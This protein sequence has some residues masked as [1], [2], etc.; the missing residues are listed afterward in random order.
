MKKRT[1]KTIQRKLQFLATVSV[2]LALVLTCTAF[3]TYGVLNLRQTKHQQVKTQ[4]ALLAQ[5]SAAAVEFVDAVQADRLL[6][7]LRAEPSVS[8]AGL[9]T[10]NSELIGGYPSK[11]DATEAFESNRLLLQGKHI[12]TQAVFADGETVGT[13]QMAVD[14]STVR[15]AIWN[16]AFIALVVGIGAWTVAIIVAGRLQR[17]IVEPIR[18]LGEVARK[19][20]LEGD[21]GHRVEILSDGEIGELI[22]AFNDLLAQTESSKRGL[23]D[24]KDM[25]ERRVAER[26]IE[27]EKACESAQAASRAK[28]DFLAN[29]SHEIRTPLNAIM[30]YADL[31]RRGWEDSPEE[32]N[33][34]LHT[35]HS[36]GRH[37][38]TVINDILDI[39]K[40]EAGKIELEVR[41]ESPQS[42]LSEVV[43]LL[44]VP[45]RE[46]QLNLEYTW[47]GPV[48]KKVL[49]DGSRLKQ[50]LINL[51]GNGRKFTLTGGV[52]INA[53]LNTD[54]ARAKLEID[55]LDTGV[56][57]PAEAQTQI[58]EPFVQADTSVTRKFGGTGL[59]LSISRRLARMMGG[60]LTVESEL[61]KGSCFHLTIDAGDV[62]AIE[63]QSS[64]VVGDQIP[65]KQVAHDMSVERNMIQGLRVL[66]VDDGATNRKLVSVVLSRV[67]AV[68]T[69]AENGKEACELVIA[70]GKFDVILMDMQMPVMDGYAASTKLREIGIRTPIIALTAHAMASDKQQCLSAG[71]SDYLSKPIDTNELLSRM[72]AIH[73]STEIGATMK[74]TESILAPIASLLPT[75]DEEFAEIVADFVQALDR[76]TT[77]LRDAVNNRDATQTLAI[78]HWVKGSGGTAGFPCLTSPAVQLHEAV[79][80][81]QWDDANRLLM[82]I[83]DYLER[84]V[85]PQIIKQTEPS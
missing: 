28:S 7:C 39:S 73:A 62:D 71:C 78:A 66:V 68:I 42:I 74:A 30:G 8:Y 6:S 48:P 51:V 55:I 22:H 37:L 46:K 18:R 32:R 31:L 9:F 57:I 38:M 16:Y 56:G 17:G 81:D 12:V 34:M 33:E 64:S 14:F 72:K 1:T 43:S 49:I 79:K 47:Q 63:V 52:C 20:T 75:E 27:L 44:R 85:S 11:S 61:G 58:F 3:V 59:G 36:S 53:K 2:T 76:E 29:M 35:L 67:G 19:V 21:Y 10:I 23:Q 41:Q 13:L 24:A 77:K 54:S 40:I 25:L 26:T 15:G 5:N 83:E 50:I 69:Q 82:T 84:M 45:F 65:Q 80:T 4:A 60:D 70:D